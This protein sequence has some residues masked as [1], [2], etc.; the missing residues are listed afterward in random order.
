ESL[1]SFFQSTIAYASATRR[2]P[3]GG[4]CCSASAFSVPRSKPERSSSPS[5][6]SGRLDRDIATS[7][8]MIRRSTSA[9]RACSSVCMHLGVPGVGGGDAGRDRL[10]VAHLAEQDHVGVL[11]ESGAQRLAERD[12][13]GADLAL[14]DYAALVLVHEL[15]RVLDREDVIG[16]RAVDLVDDRRERRRL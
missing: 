15:D 2:P 3:S 16:A 4:C 7:A 8:V 5:S 14:V 11:A 10:G 13:V 12:R 6:W 1:M 9:E